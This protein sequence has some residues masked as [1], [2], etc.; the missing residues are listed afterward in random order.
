M[1]VR[2]T[3]LLL[4]LVLA[5]CGVRPT[6]PVSA[7]DPPVGAAPGP[8]LFFLK[9]GKLAPVVRQTGHLGT[10][11]DAVTL[12]LAGPNPQ[13]AAAGYATMLPAGA[14]GVSVGALD[15]GVVTV[16]LSAPLETLPEL[17]KDQIVCTVTAVHA[18]TG[19]RAANLLVRLTGPPSATQVDGYPTVT[20]R[21]ETQAPAQGRSCP[22]L[23]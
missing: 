6:D 16:S 11:P 4:V 1:T 15:Q 8:I 17:A 14:L 9:A 2:W 20:A 19:A 7:G 18:Q 12:L 3:W 5:G 10:V 22:L 23:H 13:E 21:P